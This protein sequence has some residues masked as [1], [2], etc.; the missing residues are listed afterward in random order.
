MTTIRLGAF[1]HR[2]R[3]QHIGLL[4][5]IDGRHDF[6]IQREPRRH[7]ADD[8]EVFI[9]ERQRLADDLRVCAEAALPEPIT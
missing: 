4:N 6:F 3:Q 2:Q 7:D 1:A 9:I 5:R 8:G